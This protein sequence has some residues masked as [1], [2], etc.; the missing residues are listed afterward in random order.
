MIVHHQ[1]LLETSN[2]NLSSL[3][4]I[5]SDIGKII[6]ALKMNKAYGHNEIS[7]RMLKL[8]ES[9][10]TEQ[11][12]LIFKNRLSSDTFP[13]VW[14]KAS[15]IPIYKKDDNKC[16]KFIVICLCYRSVVRYLKN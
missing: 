12:Y 1:T 6:K 15:V 13:G 11:L 7:I 8:C 16:Y 9:V 4:I 2:E 5:A 3:E 10:I 14:K